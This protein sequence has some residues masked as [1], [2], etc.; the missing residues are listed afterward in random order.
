[1]A[2]TEMEAMVEEGVM[3]V[4]ADSEEVEAFEEVSEVGADTNNGGRTSRRAEGMK[5]GVRQSTVFNREWRIVTNLYWQ[6]RR[7]PL[8]FLIWNTPHEINRIFGCASSQTFRDRT[9]SIQC[10]QLV[11]GP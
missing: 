9:D 10:W 5:D 11:P 6:M 2:A 1:M 4:E 8:L 7:Y 3:V